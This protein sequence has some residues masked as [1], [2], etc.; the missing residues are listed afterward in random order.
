MGSFDTC[1][2]LLAA[3]NAADM[4]WNTNAVPEVL[5]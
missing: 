1:F 4:Q 2:I 3:L 5:Y